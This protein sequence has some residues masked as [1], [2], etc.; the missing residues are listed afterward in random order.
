M[1]TAEASALLSRFPSF[2]SASAVFEAWARE[3]KN[4]FLLSKS[5]L[6]DPTP[7]SPSCFLDTDFSSGGL[8]LTLLVAS[9]V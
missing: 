4:L 5:S 6:G 8:L 9:D 3:R 1:S 7:V 2:R